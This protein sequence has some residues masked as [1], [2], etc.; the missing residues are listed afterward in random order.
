MGGGAD[1][2]YFEG[3]YMI[4]AVLK[5]KN[6]D[7]TPARATRYRIVANWS[8]ESKVWTVLGGQKGAKEGKRIA[9][10]QSVYFNGKSYP[11]AAYG[12][13]FVKEALSRVPMTKDGKAISEGRDDDEYVIDRILARRK[14][15]EGQYEYEVSWKGYDD[16]T[17]EP[18][19]NVKDT[20]AFEKFKP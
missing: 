7:T 19:N 6:T 15:S 13:N 8:K 10:S 12:R 5:A 20:R 3:V 2:K 1:K 16:T 14:N 9:V 4:H 18:E 11:A 17:W